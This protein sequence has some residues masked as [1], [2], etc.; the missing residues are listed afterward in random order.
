MDFG[1]TPE[2]NAL[3]EEVRQ[4]IADNVTPEVLAEIES[5]EERGVG[6]HYREL[7]KKSNREGMGRNQLAR[8]VRRPGR[9]PD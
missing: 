4:F 8:G 6:P 1:F 3:A 7:R 2:Q 9:K 5:E